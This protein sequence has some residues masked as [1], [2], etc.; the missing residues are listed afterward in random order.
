MS[1]L[2]S[3]SYGLHQVIG[4]LF[5]HLVWSAQVLPWAVTRLNQRRE[6]GILHPGYRINCVA[7]TMSRHLFS[8]PEN[9]LPH[10]QCAIQSEKWGRRNLCF[11]SSSLTLT[12]H[13]FTPSGRGPVWY[14]AFGRHHNAVWVVDV[15]DHLCFLVHSVL[16]HLLNLP[17][18]LLF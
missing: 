7:E 6:L 12:F 13:L 5:S 18:L 9:S 11:P 10:F 17:W 8:C 3:S 4:R 16:F 2:P 14:W 1:I 15:L